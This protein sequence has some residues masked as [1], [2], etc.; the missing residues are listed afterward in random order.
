MLTGGFQAY[1]CNLNQ[2]SKCHELPFL[3]ELR[4]RVKRA[5]APAKPGNET[6]IREKRKKDQNAKATIVNTVPTPTG[7]PDLAK[8]GVILPAPTL[9]GLV[10]LPLL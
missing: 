1:K 2:L 10:H 4:V 5:K 9:T 6:Q 8:K 7:A 3:W